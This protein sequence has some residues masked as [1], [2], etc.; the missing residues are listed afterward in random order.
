MLGQRCLE[1]EREKGRGT[2]AKVNIIFAD[3]IVE[4][5]KYGPILF[6]TCKRKFYTI[7]YVAIN[8]K[9]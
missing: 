5:R 2:V 3:G 4:T 8:F 9:T 6:G 1:T 7:L